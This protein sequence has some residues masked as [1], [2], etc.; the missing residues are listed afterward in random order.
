MKSLW[1]QHQL[2]HFPSRWIRLQCLHTQSYLTLYD[3]M[4]CSPQAPQS[5]AFEGKNTEVGSH[6]LL[7]GTSQPRD[8]TQ[9]SCTGSKILNSEP[10]GKPPFRGMVR[11]KKKKKEIAYP[12]PISRNTGSSF[13]LQGDLGEVL[14]VEMVSFPPPTPVTSSLQPIPA[15]SF[16]VPLPKFQACVDLWATPLLWGPAGPFHWPPV[17]LGRM[18]LI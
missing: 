3:P 14:Q 1:P 7:R 9:A 15:V 10:S 13:L 2:H 11:G 17:L 12:L 18:P 5:I 6:F 4:G 16:P 8:W